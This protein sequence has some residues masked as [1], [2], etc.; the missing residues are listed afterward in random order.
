MNAGL[1][2]YFYHFWSQVSH[3]VIWN[4]KVRQQLHKRCSGD[5]K[6]PF[7]WL[8]TWFEMGQTSRGTAF[9]LDSILATGWRK[10]AKPWPMREVLKSKASNM[11]WSDFVPCRSA[12]DRRRNCDCSLHIGRVLKP[13]ALMQKCNWNYTDSAQISAIVWF[14]L[15]LVPSFLP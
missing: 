5:N 12:W 14:F 8:H 10:R 11:F 4:L 9:I 3:V 2:F 7:P 13:N 15:S 1:F 6:C